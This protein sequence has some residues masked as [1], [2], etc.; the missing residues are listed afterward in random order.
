M[1]CFVGF[2]LVDTCLERLRQ[3]IEPFCTFLN[4]ELDWK[5]RMVLPKNWHMPGLLFQDLNEDE[6]FEVW[7]EVKRN[8]GVGVWNDMLFPWTGLALW[9]TPRR[10]SMI[11]LDAPAYPEANLWPLASKLTTLPFAKADTTHFAEY[12]PQITLVRFSGPVSRPYAREWATPTV[13]KVLPL[14]PP[15]AIRFDRVSMF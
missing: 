14:V 8:V 4:E 5:V 1:R 12:R 10:P 6:R 9:P 13:R 15:S 7:Q 2:E 3:R 11:C